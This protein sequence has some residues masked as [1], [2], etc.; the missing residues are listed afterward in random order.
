[1]QFHGSTHGPNQRCINRFCTCTN[2]VAACGSGSNLSWR[3][4]SGSDLRGFVRRDG[5]ESD[6]RGFFLSQGGGKE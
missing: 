4:G 2:A 3:C 1:M 5:Q 6:F